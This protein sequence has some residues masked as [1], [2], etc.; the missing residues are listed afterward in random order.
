M[1]CSGTFLDQVVPRGNICWYFSANKR[2]VLSPNKGLTSLIN[3]GAGNGCSC[4]C[5]V[6]LTSPTFRFLPCILLPKIF[7][8]SLA[9]LA[10]HLSHHFISRVENLDSSPALII[11]C[12]ILHNFFDASR[13]EKTSTMEKGLDD[14]IEWL[15]KEIAFASLQG[16]FKDNLP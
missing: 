15:L 2:S 6:G 16:E 4:L 13:C 5:K 3:P 14:L 8:R 10:L 11:L 9:N 1:A 7:S 12:I